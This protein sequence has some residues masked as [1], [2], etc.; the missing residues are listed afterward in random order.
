MDGQTDGPPDSS[1]TTHTHT[2][3]HT[4]THNFVAGGIISYKRNFSLICVRKLKL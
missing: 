4:H 1:I 3:R 2:H